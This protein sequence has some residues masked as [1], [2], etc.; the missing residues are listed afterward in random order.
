MQAILNQLVYLAFLQS[1]FLL[2]SYAFSR[3]IRK[4]VNPYLI[5]L[6]SVMMIGLLG[7]IW[8]LDFDGIQR[9]YSLSEYAV[10]LFG[11]TVYLFTKSSLHG[12]N[13]LQR[14]DLIHYIPGAVYIV[15]LSYYYV[16][17]P[18]EV[19]NQRFASGQLFWMVVLFMGIGLIVNGTYWIL[20]VK[21]FLTQKRRLSAESSYVINFG[22]FQNFLFAVGVC[23]ESSFLG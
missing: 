8:I 18:K 11:A 19:I 21:L 9:L 6:I 2:I 5:V 7:K 3:K 4:T 17:A 12:N 13:S 16:F 23:R 10:F 22:F 20:A 14:K 1:V 15:A